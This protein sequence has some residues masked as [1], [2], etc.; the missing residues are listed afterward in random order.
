MYLHENAMHGWMDERNMYRFCTYTLFRTLLFFLCFFFPVKV[1][2][3][4]CMYVCTCTV[5][6]GELGFEQ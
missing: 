1:D 2:I 5:Q 6:D 3:Y 4:V